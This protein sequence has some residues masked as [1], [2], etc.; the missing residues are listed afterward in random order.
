MD[1]RLDKLGNQMRIKIAFPEKI[2]YTTDIPVRITDV[3][4]GGHL[5]NDSL[6]TILHEARVRFLNSFGYSE[7][8]IEGVSIMMNDVAIMYK[9]QGYA[10]DMLEIGMGIEDISRVGCDIVYSVTNKKSGKEVARAKTGIVFFDY[11]AEKLV[12]IPNE[13][14][15]KI[16]KSDVMYIQDNNLTLF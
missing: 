16:K 13:F 10:G 2:L 1:K 9:S 7:T 5:G 4:Y 8:D 14:I 3:N 15:E 11:K 6:L 12:Q